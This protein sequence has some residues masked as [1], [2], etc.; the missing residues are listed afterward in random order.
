MSEEK[1]K[2]T[3]LPET[4]GGRTI[5]QQPARLVFYAH[6]LARIAEGNGQYTCKYH[7]SHNQ[8][9]LVHVRATRTKY[10]PT[11]ACLEDMH[12]SRAFPIWQMC[13]RYKMPSRSVFCKTRPQ[14]HDSW[15]S[16]SDISKTRTCSKARGSLDYCDVC[17]TVA[18]AG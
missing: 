9:G 16:Y 14:N 4:S 1:W 7:I 13:S 15:T 8:T 17:T 6:G 2:I 10:S 11:S 18:I 5:V 12:W 3:K